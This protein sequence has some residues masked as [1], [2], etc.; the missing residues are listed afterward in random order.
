M[1]KENPL[2]KREKYF[3]DTGIEY[4]YP[5][6]CVNE[7]LLDIRQLEATG[8]I[9]RSEMRER[10]AFQG[11]VPC[12][13]HATV[14]AQRGYAYMADKINSRRMKTYPYPFPITSET[15]MEAIDQGLQ[16]MLKQQAQHVEGDCIC[17]ECK[18]KTEDNGSNLEVPSPSAG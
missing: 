8:E 1:K 12:E 18:S 5:R 9:K 6:C 3:H 13:I 15:L 16:H 17:N 11:F 14:I 7:F 10:W 4:G 2:P